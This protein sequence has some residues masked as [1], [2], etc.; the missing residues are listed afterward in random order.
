MYHIGR[1]SRGRLIVGIGDSGIRHRHPIRELIDPGPRK[2]Q[3]VRVEGGKRKAEERVSSRPGVGDDER[4][5]EEI[6]G[7]P[8]VRP[9]GR[10]GR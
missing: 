10:S 4:R 7:R 9:I 5:V 1:V 3:E 2:G 6:G 8:P